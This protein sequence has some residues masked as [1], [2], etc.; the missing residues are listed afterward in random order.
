MGKI[1]SKNKGNSNER[2]CVKIL[3]EK[4]GD[5]L[6]ARAV[7]SGAWIGA[8]NRGRADTLTEEQRLAFASDLICPTN[9]RFV[10]EHKAYKDEATI[11][12]FFN[13]K[14][15]LKKWFEQVESD[16]EFVHKQPM[17]VIKYNNKKRIVFIKLKPSIYT[18]IY[19]DWY[20]HW[21]EEL[22]N[23][24]PKEFFFND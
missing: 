6:F 4:F 22:L 2:E 19:K 7:S 12:D 9:F 20:C 14:S 8:G 18:F 5:K 10:I 16:A 17:L 1:N 15:N 21:F 24:E 11:W 3:N 13:E 23:S